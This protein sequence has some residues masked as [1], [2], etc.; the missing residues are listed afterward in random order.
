MN[1]DRVAQP[2]NISR[3]TVNDLPM[4]NKHGIS[5]Y[6]KL[7]SDVRNDMVQFLHKTQEDT[8]V[9][10]EHRLQA[11]SI[12]LRIDQLEMKHEEFYTPK[13]SMDMSSLP[14]DALEDTLQQLEAEIKQLESNPV[15]EGELRAAED[16]YLLMVKRGQIIPECAKPVFDP[17]QAGVRLGAPRVSKRSSGEVR[18]RSP[19]T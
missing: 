17:A 9:K 7:S 11:T 14:D 4:I 8:G 2:D 16:N 10:T 1:K 19:R 13:V 12:L 3:F 5:R 18:D 15:S 6:R